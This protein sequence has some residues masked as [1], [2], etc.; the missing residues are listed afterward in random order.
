MDFSTSSW[1]PIQKI[2]W[3]KKRLKFW[4]QTESYLN[5]MFR[6]QCEEDTS[7]VASSEIQSSNKKVLRAPESCNQ[8]GPSNRIENQCNEER[9]KRRPQTNH[10]NHGEV[11]KQENRSKKK[12]HQN[13]ATIG[14]FSYFINLNCF[15]V[16]K[17]VKLI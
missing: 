1:N 8:I 12:E 16:N 2:L 5:P 11:K 13:R 7:N 9:V 10:P 15:C 3:I 14:N 6:N 17:S 4:K